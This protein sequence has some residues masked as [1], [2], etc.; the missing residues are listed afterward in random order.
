MQENVKKAAA[1]AAQTMVIYG[2]S[3][4]RMT[5]GISYVKRLCVPLAPFGKDASARVPFVNARL[6]SW[7]PYVCIGPDLSRRKSEDSDPILRPRNLARAL[8]VAAT[9]ARLLDET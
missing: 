4:R 8:R 2:L 3:K 5:T 9:I 6:V 7:C 1:R